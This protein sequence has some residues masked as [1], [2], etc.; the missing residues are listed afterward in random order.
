MTASARRWAALAALVLAASL[1]VVGL[2]GSVWVVPAAA[3]SGSTSEFRPIFTDPGAPCLR[4]TVLGGDGHVRLQSDCPATVIVLGYEDEPYLEFSPS[5]VRENRNSPAG[6]LNVDSRA[7][8]SVPPSARPE[9]QPD[10]VLRGNAPDYSWHDHRIH[11]M[12]DEAPS[13]AGGLR[14]VADWMIP[15]WI[16]DD[17]PAGGSAH[18]GAARGELFYE[19]PIAPWTPLA[20]AAATALGAL[21]VALVRGLRRSDRFRTA[22]AALVRPVS[23][24]M[25]VIAGLTLVRAID[26]LVRASGA[27][28]PWKASAIVTVIITGGSLWAMGR[29]WRGDLGGVLAL[30]GAGAALSWTFGQVDAALLRAPVLL[31]TMAPWF[32]R[33]VV[34]L[35]LLAVIPPV[36]VLIVGWAARRGGDG[37]DGGVGPGTSA[38]PM[39]TGVEGP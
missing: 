36:V 18:H 17:G 30:V 19:P 8:T 39:P 6:Y 26:D 4:W 15:M 9:A 12:S 1:V 13:Q 35:Q 28:E 25:G 14:K 11:W 20:L 33:W 7:S 22:N 2:L 21:V 16:D 23:A 27:G 3:H 34:A 37:D 24:L 5:G 10:W 32:L 38:A 31:S 29:S